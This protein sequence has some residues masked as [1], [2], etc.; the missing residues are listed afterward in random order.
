MPSKSTMLPLMNLPTKARNYLHLIKPLLLVIVSFF[1]AFSCFYIVRRLGRRK[2]KIESKSVKESLQDFFLK[3]P[4]Q[5]STV[6]A[7]FL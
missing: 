2:G 4:R 7:E 5:I 3:F 6:H 1:S